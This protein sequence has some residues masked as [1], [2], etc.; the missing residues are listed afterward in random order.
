MSSSNDAQEKERKLAIARKIANSLLDKP[1]AVKKNTEESTHEESVSSGVLP[2]AQTAEIVN[3]AAM[4]AAQDARLKRSLKLILTNKAKHLY[5]MDIEQQLITER[6]FTLLQNEL[7]KMSGIEGL[8]L[9]T[10][11][12]VITHYLEVSYWI[13]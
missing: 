4:L 3:S 10:L 1:G 7:E 12:E 8:R 13:G 2:G 11:V 9:P 6:N 5:N